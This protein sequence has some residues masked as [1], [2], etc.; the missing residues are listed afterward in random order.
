MRE[1]TKMVVRNLVAWQRDLDLLINTTLS[2]D[3]RGKIITI[4]TKLIEA[5]FDL[6]DAD[7]GQQPAQS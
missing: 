5:Q 3:L 1:T 4:K 2:A 7:R 6:E